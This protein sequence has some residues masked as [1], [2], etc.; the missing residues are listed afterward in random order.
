MDEK[1]LRRQPTSHDQ[2]GRRRKLN[3]QVIDRERQPFLWAI[4]RDK[5]LHV[6]MALTLVAASPL[7]G[8][9]GCA[10]C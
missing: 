9:G 3:I 4:N 10:P 2:V 5:H 1:L 8:R 7:S 6:A